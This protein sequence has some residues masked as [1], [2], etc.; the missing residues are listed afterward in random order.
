[1]P[2][3]RDVAAQASA[4]VGAGARGDDRPRPG[5]RAYPGVEDATIEFPRVE[6]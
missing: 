1:M 6:L 3:P 4:I 2:V 5:S